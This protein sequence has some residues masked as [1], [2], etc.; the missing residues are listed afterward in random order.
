MRLGTCPCPRCL[1]A[2]TLAD[3]DQCELK[4]F[5]PPTLH[6]ITPIIDDVSVDIADM[7][8]PQLKARLKQLQLPATGNKNALIARLSLSGH[9]KQAC[10][11]CY[12]R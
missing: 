5:P 4:I 8:V 2:T 10:A 12:H 11:I 1:A 9:L 6:T 3:F 7:T